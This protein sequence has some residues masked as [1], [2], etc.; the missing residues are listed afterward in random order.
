MNLCTWL[1]LGGLAGWLASIIKGANK[2]MGLLAN[3]ATG[4]IGALVGGWVLRLAGGAGVC[5]LNLYSL[6]VATAGAVLL[7]TVVQAVRK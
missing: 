1:V 5:G 4:I 6:V 7:L 2:R 3:V